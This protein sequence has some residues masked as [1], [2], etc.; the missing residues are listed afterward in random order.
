MGNNP[1]EFNMS[2]RQKMGILFVFSL[3]LGACSFPSANKEKVTSKPSDE[4]EFAV[5]A[6]NEVSP[7]ELMETKEI[8]V[9]EEKIAEIAIP[10]ETPRPP[11]D[12][13]VEIKVEEKKIAA[14]MV[15]GK[16]DPVLM[17]EG[18]EFK[19]YQKAIVS[20]DVQAPTAEL[21]ESSSLA[22]EESYIIQKNDTMMMIAFKIYGDYRKWKDL[23]KWNSEKLKLK[24]KEGDTLKYFAPDKSFSW[25]P[26]GL[27]YMVK[28][29]D[30][31]Q[32]VSVDK[33]G[34]P[35]K[36]KKI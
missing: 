29:G 5:D 17:P 22:K 8:K 13:K 30:T 11:A 25:Q 24:M 14:S 1:Q 33:Y 21:E 16:E 19:D 7:Q 12:E 23:K 34:T 3:L 32:K 27:P 26:N 28:I 18:P 9:E 6:F 4:L 35:K 10:D 31:L 2:T 20:Q 15:E 36:W